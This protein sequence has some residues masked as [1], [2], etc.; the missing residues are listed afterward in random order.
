MARETPGVRLFES[1]PVF[2]DAQTCFQSGDLGPFYWSWGHLNEEG[3]A[4]L[5]HAFLPWLHKTIG[6][7]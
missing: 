1:L 5:L 7:E 4:R 2:C 3:S 6:G